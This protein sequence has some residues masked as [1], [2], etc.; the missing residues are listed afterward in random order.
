M[1]TNFS[2]LRFDGKEVP[3]L[4]ESSVQTK[5][6]HFHG[7]NNGRWDRAKAIPRFEELQ[8]MVVRDRISEKGRQLEEGILEEWKKEKKQKKRKRKDDM[9]ADLEPLKVTYYDDEGNVVEV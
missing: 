9:E 7:K 3:H 6:T 8:A 4:K 1:L 2:D 5:Y